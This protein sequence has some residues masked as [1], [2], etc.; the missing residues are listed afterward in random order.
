MVESKESKE[1][2]KDCGKQSSRFT[3]SERINKTANGKNVMKDG[4]FRLK[5]ALCLYCLFLLDVVNQ[6]Y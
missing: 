4:I 3:I 1:G 2:E 6:S 5:L